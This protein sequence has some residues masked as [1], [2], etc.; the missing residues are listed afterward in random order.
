MALPVYDLDHLLPLSVYPTNELWNLVPCDPGFNQGRKKGMLPTRERLNQ[1]EALVEKTYRSYMEHP[2][3][4]AVLLNDA[5]QRFSTVTADRSCDSFPTELAGAVCR[6]LCR[7]GKA[8]RLPLFD[9][10]GVS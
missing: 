6:M 3:L 5:R 8:R 7:V 10:P 4:S 9:V 2:E 1:A